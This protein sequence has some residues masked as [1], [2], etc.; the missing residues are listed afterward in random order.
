MSVKTQDKKEEKIDPLVEYFY[1]IGPNPETIISD[2]FY[3]NIQNNP[4]DININ[5]KI[6]SKFP[7]VEKPLCSIKDEI[8]VSHCFPN[9]FYLLKED[10]HPEHKIFHFS[11]QNIFPQP[12][13]NTKFIYFTCLKFYEPVSN[14][15]EINRRNSYS[16]LSDINLDEFSGKVKAFGKFFKRQSVI[17]KDNPFLFSERKKLFEKYYVP[18]VICF[19]SLAPFPYE[20]GYLLNKIIN[21]TIHP[22]NKST[23]ENSNNNNNNNNDKEVINKNSKEV[24]NKNDKDAIK[25]NDKEIINNN[26][27]NKNKDNENNNK[28]DDK[29]NN[30]KDNNDK[31]NNDNN[32]NKDNDK[33]NDNNDNNDK[34]DDNNKNIIPLEKIIEKIVMET[35]MPSRGI[36]YINFQNNNEFF[37]KN[38]KELII[39]QSE[40]N[41]YYIPSYIMQSIFIFNT[42]DIIDIY[43][44]LLLEIPILFFS[45]DIEKLTNIFGT[46]I[47]LIYPFNCQCP[48]VSVLPDINSAA[49]QNFETFVFGINQNWKIKNKKDKE[50]DYFERNKMNIYNKAILICDIDKSQKEVYFKKLNKEHIVNF[51]DLGK[52]NNT[53]NLSSNNINHNNKYDYIK[54][55]LP[56]HYFEKLKR[57]LDNFINT[58]KNIKINGYNNEYNEEMNKQIS[59]ESFFYF[60]VSILSKYN[61]YLYNTE[62]EIKKICE[63]IFCKNPDKRDINK[64]FN[65]QKFLNEC[66]NSDINF[67]SA[68]FK[69]EM[70]NDFISRKYLNKKKDKIA[71]LHFDEN[72]IKKRNKG[73]LTKKCETNFIDIKIFSNS[74]NYDISDYSNFKEDELKY[75]SD[76][77]KE[78]LDYYQTYNGKEFKYLV[79]PKLLYDNKFFKNKKYIFNYNYNYRASNF[80][81]VYNDLLNII[82]SDKKYFKI[83]NGDLIVQD[84]FNYNIFLFDNEIQNSLLLLWLRMFCLTFYYCDKEE[85]NLRFYEMIFIIKRLIYIKDDIFSLI[86]STLEKYGT[87]IMMI[88][89]FS[90][91]NSNNYI[92]YSY[93]THKL[94]K[95]NQTKSA[96]KEMR[97]SN[98]L[99]T[100]HYYI[101]NQDE[102]IIPHI[103]K[104]DVEKFRERVFGINNNNTNEN[105]QQKEK[106]DIY[107]SHNIKCD[108]CGVN[109]E[110]TGLTVNYKDMK[111]THHLICNCKS[112]LTDKITIKINGKYYK[113]LLYEPYYLYKIVSNELLEKYGNQIPIDELRT[114]YKDFY[115]NC[116]WYFWTQGLSYDILLKYKNDIDVS[117]EKIINTKND[118]NKDNENEKNKKKKKKR[119]LRFNNLEISNNN[120]NNITNVTK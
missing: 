83:Y 39:K 28:N 53:N 45:K 110:I 52:T 44:C 120:N 6:L 7:P 116:I 107:F 78:L 43:K 2:D 48:N 34:K 118:N 99:L 9:G 65:A 29:D 16:F 80:I 64:M 117:P 82:L 21:Y 66:K 67:Y 88:Q 74:N 98:T 79:F 8:I 60:L 41:E 57:K 77:K 37:R 85:K 81:I 17:L 68:F 31:N 24:I 108:N 90:T 84:K 30:D 75:I 94:L 95:E 55:I 97:V 1:I 19:C 49:I 87:D 10:Q 5:A 115:W 70:F 89:F 33:K 73:F 51:K 102:Y 112:Q 50:E 96:F 25:T 12:L 61:N 35:P 56:Y 106:E 47:S 4:N 13:G 42:Q 86:L 105:L 71:F 93:L 54:Y 26:Q 20:L 111:K 113:I 72:I 109:L 63:Y 32:D 76:N 119:K 27:D 58:N 38:E 46:F 101:D 100:I 36:F 104:D 62:N 11:L 92:Q 3:I 14:Y 59:E 40:I 23:N 114:K 103:I 18:K 69:T 91:L 15:Y 22:N